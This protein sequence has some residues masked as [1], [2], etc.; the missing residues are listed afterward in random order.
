MKIIEASGELETLK[1]YIKTNE[2]RHNS[3]L[4]YQS[5]LS[6]KFK[7][8]LVLTLKNVFINLKF[9]LFQFKKLAK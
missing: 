4:K 1:S 9:D 2:N 6:V 5:K 3:D 7:N 8:V